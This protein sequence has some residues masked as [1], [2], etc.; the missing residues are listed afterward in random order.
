VTREEVWNIWRYHPAA[1]GRMVGFRDLTDELHG[2]WM[3][4][5]LYGTTDYT[6]QAH[7][8]SYKSSCL[9]VALAM[10]C[11]LH[12]GENALFMRKTDADTVESIAQAKKVFDNEGFRYMAA[13]LLRTNVELVKST[14]NSLTVNVYDSPRGAEQ[15][16]GCGCGGS[17]T[18]K[19]AN[20]IVCD[21]V[22]NLQDRVSRAERERTKA[23]VQEL[24]NIVTRDGRI[25]FIGT[26]WHKED[27]FTLVAEP[28]RHDCYTTGLITTEK[29]AE[30]K[31]SMSP[32]LFAANYELRHIAAENALFDIHPGHTDNPAL[33]RDGI[34]HID[35]AYGGEDYTALTCAKRRGDT[36][37]L[38]G[39]LWRAHVDT[40]LDAALT[41]CQ[42]LQCAPVYCESNGDKGYLGK[43]IRNRGQE[44]RIYAEYQNKYLKISTYLRKWWRNIV[45]LDGTDRAYIAQIMDYT[46]DAEHDD[47]PDSA[48]V[49]CRLLDKDRRSLLGE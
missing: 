33:L 9:S 2:K 43:E 36:L 5:I 6:L 18:G 4:H 12:H 30:L 46:E 37:Y 40:V 48:A 24:R 16:L 10:W 41:E 21:D 14:A 15:L 42:R 26:P 1:V 25:V 35:A 31:S 17:M 27:A 45:F 28:E 19:H 34:A 3:Q 32:S 49:A 11:V 22:V 47:A 8:L 29:L 23:V 44:A 7:R 38:Y 20:L 39:R 13:L